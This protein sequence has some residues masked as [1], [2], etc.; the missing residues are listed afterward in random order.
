MCGFLW[1]ATLGKAKI[2][3]LYWW[4]CETL[5]LTLVLLI[6]G[7][8]CMHGSP[9]CLLGIKLRVYTDSIEVE[10]IVILGSEW[11]LHGI[12]KLKISLCHVENLT[13]PLLQ[14][15]CSSGQEGSIMIHGSTC[16]WTAEA[17]VLMFKPQNCPH[18]ISCLWFVCCC[19]HCRLNRRRW[20][21]GD[22]L[23][24]S[25]CAWGGEPPEQPPDTPAESD[26][27]LPAARACRLAVQN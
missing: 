1:T 6:C 24:L 10:S 17:S 8:C 4:R 3:S 25:S 13:R 12:Q 18:C 2:C 22:T 11:T 5:S 7:S 15:F 21:R 27:L 20:R 19:C 14:L 26:Q 16:L 9:Q 23:S